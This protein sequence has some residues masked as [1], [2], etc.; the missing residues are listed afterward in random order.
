VLTYIARR[1]LWLVVVLAL[2]SIVT[3]V[4][5]YAVPADPARTFAPNASAQ[6]VAN[7]R[8]QWGLDQPLWVQYVRYLGRLLHG[9]LGWSYHISQPVLSAILQRAPATAELA[10]AGLIME[11]AI[12]IPVGIASAVRQYGVADRAGMVL[13]LIGV[14]APTFGVGLLLLYYF[15]YVLGWFPLSGFGPGFPLNLSYLFLPA[16]AIGLSGGAYY[17]RLL[18]S[19]LLDVLKAD[20]VRTARA[21]GLG[22]G[23]VILRHAL[24]NAITPVVTQI[25]LD[26]G[27]FL[28]GIVVVEQVFAWPGI[29]FQAWQ[30]IDNLDVPMIMGTVLFAAFC[31]TLMNL[32]IDVLYAFIDPR[33]SLT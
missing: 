13:S 10:V 18:R 12:G 31:V 3:F 29:G 5:I 6:A 4:V 23:R 16:L 2:I 11:L 25:G 19:S 8:H 7:I 30:A 26:F 20:Y 15:G 28:G 24:P 33:V 27:Y 22:E 14:S 17:A 21:K 9:D 1:L 32:V